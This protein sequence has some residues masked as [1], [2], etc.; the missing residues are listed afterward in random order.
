MGM[1]S[2]C[3]FET[4]RQAQPLR[5]KR[6]KACFSLE[7][8]EQMKKLLGYY[9]CATGCLITVEPILRFGTQ[10]LLIGGLLIFIGG[11]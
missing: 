4:C 3:V 7:F 5:A 10:A 6:S 9:Y 1:D 2:S 11:P 8:T